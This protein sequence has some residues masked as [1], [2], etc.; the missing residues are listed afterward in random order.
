MVRPFLDPWL[1]TLPSKLNQDWRRHVSKQKRKVTNS[2]AY[3]AALRQPGSST[4][5]FTVE[6]GAA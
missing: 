5:W 4:V 1:P 2:A 3:D 6:A